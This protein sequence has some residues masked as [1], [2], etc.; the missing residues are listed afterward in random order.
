[1]D[2]SVIGGTGDEGFGLTLRLARAGHRVTIGSRVAEKG[3]AVAD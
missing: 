1:M 2:I 3:S